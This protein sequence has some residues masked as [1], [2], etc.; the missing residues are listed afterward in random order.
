MRLAGLGNRRRVAVVCALALGMSTAAACGGDDSDDEEGTTAT[1][2]PAAGNTDET[3]G[4]ADTGE[5]MTVKFMQLGESL[6]WMPF[7][8]ARGQDCYADNNLEVE[9]VTGPTNAQ[10]ATQAMEQGEADV[11]AVGTTGFLSALAADRDIVAFGAG[12]KGDTSLL[13]L[14]NEVVDRLAEDGVTPDSPLEE[15]MEALRGLT[16]GANTAGGPVF[17][18]T[19]DALREF[20]LEGEVT[21][22]AL[23]GPPAMVGALQAGQID[24]FVYSP[25]PVIQPVVTDVGQ[26]WIDGPSGDVDVWQRGYYWVY[27]TKPSFAEEQPE[28]LQTIIDC[29]TEAS[30]L[31]TSD[32][33]AAAEAAREFFPSLED[34][35]YRESFDALIPVFTEGPDPSEEGYQESVDRFNASSDSE[36]DR[37]FADVFVDLG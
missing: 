32:P 15:R 27:V 5:P 12:A 2:A 7:L 37:P 20:G 16:I 11:L 6:T 31:L 22:Q 36:F 17:L 14:R 8:V 33:D 24:G 30:D 26:I 34:D 28:V 4:D 1:T 9:W 13:V 35:V 23:D 18:A 3:T 10:Q 19:E 21:L 29:V 25:P